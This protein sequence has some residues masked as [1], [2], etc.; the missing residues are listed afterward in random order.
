M[1]EQV[2]RGGRGK[3]TKPALVHINLRIPESVLEFYKRYPSYTAKMR[4]VLTQYKERTESQDP[5]T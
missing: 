1:E 3:G 4:E 2:K 5:D